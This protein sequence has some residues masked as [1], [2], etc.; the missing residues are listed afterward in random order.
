MFDAAQHWFGHAWVG[1]V[2]T[3]DT[4]KH[5]AVIRPDP[6]QSYFF[7]LCLSYDAIYGGVI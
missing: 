3:I 2:S 1:D 4:G 7:G 6:E 5:G